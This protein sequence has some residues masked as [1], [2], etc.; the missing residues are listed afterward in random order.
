MTKYMVIFGEGNMRWLR[1][2][3]PLLLGENVLLISVKSIWFITSLSFTVSLFCFWF[4]DLSISETGVLKAPTI[5][6]WGS[7]CVLS[8]SKVSFMNLGAVAFV[9]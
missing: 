6:V 5:F 1:T 9:A 3:F 7:M 8:F 2:S 4:N